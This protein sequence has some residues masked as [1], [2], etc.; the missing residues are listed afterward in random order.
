MEPNT[1]CSLV[2]HLLPS[3]NK[4]HWARTHN[5]VV[6]NVGLARKTI[7]HTQTENYKTREN[8]N[9]YHK[10]CLCQNGRDQTI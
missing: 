8:K 7:Y 6:W 4:T 9:N 2:W 3:M 1:V 10:K 5:K